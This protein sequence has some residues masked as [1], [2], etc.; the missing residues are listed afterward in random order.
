[1]NQVMLDCKHCGEEFKAPLSDISKRNSRCPHCKTIRQHS[2]EETQLLLKQTEEQV[3]Q[4]AKKLKGRTGKNTD[5]Y[6]P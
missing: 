3:D 6:L 2:E 1:M 5:Q 4:L